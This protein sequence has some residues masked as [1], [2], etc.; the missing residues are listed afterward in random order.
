[1]TEYIAGGPTE[2]PIEI[3]HRL[4]WATRD[5]A[6]RTRRDEIATKTN[7]KSEDRTG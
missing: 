3:L 5:L 4:K 7:E 1:M 2:S 6:I